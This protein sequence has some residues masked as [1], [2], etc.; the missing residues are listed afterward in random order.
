MLAQTK[1]KCIF[2]MSN[3]IGLVRDSLEKISHDARLITL[4]Q[5][6]IDA[7]NVNDLLIPYRSD[8]TFDSPQIQDPDNYI[9]L[10]A[11]TSGTTGPPKG[12]AISHKALISHL[13]YT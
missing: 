13:E 5:K 9:G 3:N 6:T 8:L 11:T 1:P 12:V 2:C 4:D 10:I 7:E